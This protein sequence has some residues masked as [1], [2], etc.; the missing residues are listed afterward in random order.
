MPN[1]VALAF[2][3]QAEFLRLVRLASADVGTRAGLDYEEIDDLKIAV[4]ECCSLLLGGDDP[5][6]LEFGFEDGCVTVSGLGSAGDDVDR[7]LSLAI[8]AAVVDEHEFT[9]DDGRERF[10]VVKHHRG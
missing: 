8:V 2:P 5:L 10:R 7:S 6:R 4:S 1:H 9:A 3:A